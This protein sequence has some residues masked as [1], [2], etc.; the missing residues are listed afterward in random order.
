MNLFQSVKME[1]SKVQWPTKHQI[2][3]STA[4]VI[5][6]TILISIYLGV[7]DFIVVRC[8]KVLEALI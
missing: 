5:T 4:W 7:F 8:L 6:M 2:V 3:T 1:Y